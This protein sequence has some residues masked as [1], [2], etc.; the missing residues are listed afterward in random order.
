MESPE[1]RCVVGKQSKVFY[2]LQ[3]CNSKVFFQTMYVCV[4]YVHVF[5][6]VGVHV[7]LQ[8]HTH[9]DSKLPSD[10]LLYS[11]T[12]CFNTEARSPAEAWAWLFQLV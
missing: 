10:V 3:K 8:S 5:A 7:C 2:E 1:Q 11:K 12:P 4:V 6:S 9:G